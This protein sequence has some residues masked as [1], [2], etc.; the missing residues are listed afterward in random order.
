MHA[1]MQRRMVAYRPTVA[2]NLALACGAQSVFQRI[3]CTRSNPLSTAF[4]RHVNKNSRLLRSFDR[5]FFTPAPP[6]RRLQ[7]A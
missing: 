2:S 4:R 1:N 7:C 5:R 3:A 6:W